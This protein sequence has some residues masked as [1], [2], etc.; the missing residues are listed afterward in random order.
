MIRNSNVD[1]YSNVN[2]TYGKADTFY[3]DNVQAQTNYFNRRRTHIVNATPYI[4][5]NRNYI[6][7]PYP[8]SSVYKVNYCSFINPNYENKRVYAFVLSRNYI[9]D[10]VTELEIVEDIHQT[11]L[12]DYSVAPCFVERMHTPTDNIGDNL[13]AE[14]FDL[15]EFKTNSSLNRLTSVDNVMC[16]ILECTFDAITWVTSGYNTKTIPQLYNRSG[17]YSATQLIAF[18]VRIRDEVTG[19]YEYAS[20]E[21][22]Y[23]QFMNRM[24]SGNGGVTIN[25]VISAWLYPFTPLTTLRSHQTSIVTTENALFRTV[26]EVGKF[27]TGNE[28]LVSSRPTALD[29][30][31]PKNKKLLTYPFAQLVAYNNNGGVKNYR[32]EYFTDPTQVKFS[33]YGTTTAEA[34]L[35]IAPLNYKGFTTGKNVDF[36]ESIDTAPYPIVS[37]VGDS[38]NIWLA[39]NRN[40]YEA[41]WDNLQMGMTTGIA[42]SAVN[43]A[44]GVLSGGGSVNGSYTNFATGQTTHT[45][46]GELNKGAV[47]GSTGGM[48]SQAVNY[49]Q[50]AKNLLATAEDNSLMPNTCKGVQS[51]GI[52]YQN[53]K[54]ISFYNK[55]IDRQHAKRIDDYYTMFGYPINEIKA[56][57]RKNRTGFTFIKTVDCHINSLSMSEENR[58]RIETAFN[59]GIRFWAN[60][61]HIGDYSI[62]N[63]TL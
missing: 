4:R 9:N 14:S 17:L 7:V 54:V 30:Y 62:S 28:I 16:I 39:Q 58:E 20:N 50:Q 31:T 47:V 36:A 10:N 25:D 34:K 49:M 29:G 57:S 61:D 3:F 21:S 42:S 2:L 27:T 32:Y 59:N 22:S 45:M 52:A 26:Y 8:I 24:N 19:A 6:R 56:I 48:L 33:A 5:E 18:P 38:Y 12:F 41:Q 53:D 37:M 13:V 43:G 23:L 46:S 40:R 51:Q 63:N 15:G 1:L 44:L 60:V 35:R 11:W 55:T